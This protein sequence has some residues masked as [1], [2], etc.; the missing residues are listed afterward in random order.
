RP[1]GK[2]LRRNVFVKGCRHRRRTAPFGDAGD[3]QD[4]QAGMDLDGEAIARADALIGGEDLWAVDPHAA[5]FDQLLR[6][7]AGFGDAGVPEPFVEALAGG[8]ISGH[9]APPLLSGR[10]R[11]SS[12]SAATAYSSPLEGE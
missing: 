7:G 9:G 2:L 5:G 4:P 3:A 8:G 12:R 11:G 10:C 1:G 6:Q